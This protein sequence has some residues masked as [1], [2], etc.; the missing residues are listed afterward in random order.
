MNHRQQHGTDTAGYK[1]HLTKNCPPNPYRLTR[2]EERPRRL[3]SVAPTQGLTIS[4]LLPC[5]CFIWFLLG[6][7]IYIAASL[8]LCVMCAGE[9]HEKWR[10]FTSYIFKI[11]LMNELLNWEYQCS[12]WQLLSWCV[13]TNKR[14]VHPHGTGT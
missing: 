2:D 13:C 6:T 1:V 7:E 8:S 3:N 4:S 5:D 12:A 9:P 11:E 10:V 14:N